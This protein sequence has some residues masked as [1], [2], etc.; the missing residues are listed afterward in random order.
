[1]DNQNKPLLIVILGPTACGKSALAV[2]IAQTCG[3]EVVS[4]DSMQVYRRMD[5]GTA[6]ITLQEAA[7]IPHWL[8]D[9][10]EPDESFSVADFRQEAI[11][12]I[13]D[14]IAR[15]RQPILCGG[16]GLYINS[17]LQEYHFSAASG[18][19]QRIR[20]QLR[21][22]LRQYGGQALHDRLRQIDPAAAERIHVN[23]AHRLIRALEVWYTAGVTISSLR[24]G[25]GSPPPYRPLLIGLTRDRENLY[26]R[27]ET[28]IDLM[29]ELGLVEE[30]AALLESGISRDAVSMQGLGYRQIAAYLQGETT[31]DEAV[32]L[33]KRDTR[34]FAKRQLTWFRRDQRIRWFNLDEYPDEDRLL[35]EVLTLIGEADKESVPIERITGTVFEQ[36][37]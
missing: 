4:G 10:R 28:R 23:D 1:M 15:G 33:L 29:L 12:C 34:R 31:L 32:V 19:D 18:A 6:K 13:D 27:I 7:G 9:I 26:R 11:S 17:L 25:I 22:E 24:E 16:T 2:R 5:I 3:G 21:Q 35:Q 14:I 8:I 37:E 30:V 20:E 36:V